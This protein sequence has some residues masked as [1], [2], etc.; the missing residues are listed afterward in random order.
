MNGYSRGKEIVMEYIE[1]RGASENNLKHIDVKIPKGKLVVLAGLSGSGKSS[2]A[3]DTIASE[4]S[5]QWQAGYSAYLRN[6]LP[7]YERPAFETMEGLTPVVIVDQKSMGVNARSSVG[8]AVDTAPLLRLLFSRVGKPSAGGSMAY[9]FNHPLGMCPDCTGLGKRL[10]LVEDKLF[11]PEGTIRDGGFTFSQFAAGWQTKIYLQNPYLNP[12]K[13]LKDYSEEEWEMLKYGSD[14]PIN[15][16]THGN[17][18]GMAWNHDYEGAVVRF[19]RLYV[20][21]DISKLKKS[22]REE[23]SSYLIEA[24]CPTCGGSGLNPAAI[25]S[26]INGYN[27]ADMQDIQVS[28]LIPILEAVDSPVGRSIASQI[29]QTLQRMVDV[30]VGYLTLGRRTDTLSGGELQRLKIVR[31]LGSSLSNIT[32]IFDEP[33][34]GLHPADAGR[35]ASLLLRLRDKHNTVLVVEHSR[36]IIR[37]AD[38]VIELGPRAGVHGGEIVFQGSQEELRE[39]DTLTAQAM[40]QK[41]TLNEKPR[42]WTDSMHVKNAHLHN[43]KNVTVDIP[44]GIITAVCGV[45]GSGKSSLIRGELA[46]AYPQTIVIDQK[47]IGISSRST[48]AT[49]SGIGDLI[50][51]KF[52]KANDVGIEWFSFNSKGGCP[53]CKGKGVIKPEIAFADPVEIPCEECQGKRFNPTALSYLYQGKN[54]DEVMSLTVNQAVEFFDDSKIS[55]KLKGLQNVGLGYITLGQTTS[56]MSGGENQRLKLAS[57]LDKKG[58]I[59]ILDEPSTGLHYKDIEL[60]MQILGNM[61]DHGNTVIMIE[62]RLEMITQADW[63]IEMGPR[64][65]SQGGKVIYQGLP[66]DIIKSKDSLT[67]KY[68][69]ER[70]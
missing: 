50:R 35:I 65:G 70:M 5:R 38:Q 12:D 67:G 52:A 9:S 1:I 43:L 61:A 34:A 21:R 64:G 32:Y 33:T 28:E 62:H 31:H 2:L 58:N 16:E 24:P 22:L 8:T 26:K 10:T 40:R 49:Y 53:V 18:A 54:I 59:Y 60:L 14:Q 17:G 68:I 42:T 66:Q 51:K 3:F 48:P 7:H 36:D 20:N 45:A 30:G 41:L 4:S 6:K 46:A 44:K 15:I 57:E 39:A 47:P 11:N 23:I 69:R 63:I 13:K 37:L 56:S 55:R 27:I 29:I 19:K 25:K